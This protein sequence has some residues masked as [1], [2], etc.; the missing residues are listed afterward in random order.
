[1]HRELFAVK[2]GLEQFRA[3]ILGRRVKVV[4]DHA[5]LKWLTTL[6]PQQAKVAR[7]CMN[8]AEFDFFIEHREGERNVAPDILS[9][10]PI[11]EQ[12]AEDNVVIPRETGVITV[13]IILTAAFVPH[14]TPDLIRRT[15][16]LIRVIQFV[17]PLQQRGKH[18]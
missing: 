15:F 3:C 5:K 6:A 13:M 12:F 4:T 8:M 14:H 18:L 2:W 1:M 9:R 10:S 7:G 16:H 17:L 11:R